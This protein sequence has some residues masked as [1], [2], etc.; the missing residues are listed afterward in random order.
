MTM[1]V[2]TCLDKPGALDLRLSVRPDHVAYLEA[3]RD[4]MRVAGPLL[5]DEGNPMGSVLLL[6]ADDKAAAMAF[7]AQD[8]YAKAGLFESVTLRAWRISIGGLA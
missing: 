3:H 2:L 8:P 1:F 4:I 5:D 6:E 7:A